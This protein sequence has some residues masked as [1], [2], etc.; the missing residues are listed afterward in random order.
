MNF[1]PILRVYFEIVF[2][3]CFVRIAWKRWWEHVCVCVCN[4]NGWQI[5]IV[6]WA[7]LV[8]SDRHKSFKCFIYYLNHM[9]ILI[10]YS[11][12][13]LFYSNSEHKLIANLLKLNKKI[14]IIIRKHHIFRMLI[15]V[16]GWRFYL[17]LHIEQTTNR[18]PFGWRER[19]LNV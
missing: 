14:I 15:I 2:I 10:I 12:Q 3:K 18:M 4:E 13:F 19:K 5:C 11:T 9:L 6:C 1:L 16:F 17:H 8:A 7:F